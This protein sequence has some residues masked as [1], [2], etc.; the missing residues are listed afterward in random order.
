MRS[1]TRHLTPEELR[2]LWILTAVILM[3]IGGKIWIASHPA[4]DHGGTVPQDSTP[5]KAP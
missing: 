1:L 3:G 4:A 5:A 2:T